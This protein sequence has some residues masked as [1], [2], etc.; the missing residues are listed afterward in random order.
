VTDLQKL[1]AD[2]LQGRGGAYGW[3]G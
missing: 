2:M 3:W 1:L